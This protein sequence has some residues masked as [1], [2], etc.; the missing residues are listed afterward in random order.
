MFYHRRSERE[1]EILSVYI[2]KPQPC[3][4][5]FA[6]FSAPAVECILTSLQRAPLKLALARRHLHNHNDN[7]ASARAL[8]KCVIYIRREEKLNSP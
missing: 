2:M 3:G 7:P 4:E 8:I 5:F 1:K 6:H